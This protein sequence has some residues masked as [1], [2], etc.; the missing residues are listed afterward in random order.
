M[1]LTYTDELRKIK[2]EHDLELEGSSI[3]YILEL[4]S[5]LE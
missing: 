3:N 5:R 4:E 1:N 2:D